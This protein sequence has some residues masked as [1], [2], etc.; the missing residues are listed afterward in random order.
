MHKKLLFNDLFYFRIFSIILVL[1]LFSNC[2]TTENATRLEKWSWMIQEEDKI[3]ESS[4]SEF[5]KLKPLV[6]R[7][8]FFKEEEATIEEYDL[9]HISSRNFAENICGNIFAQEIRSSKDWVERVN[10]YIST[11]N[12]NVETLEKSFNYKLPDYAIGSCQSVHPNKQFTLDDILKFVKKIRENLDNPQKGN[13]NARFK[14]LQNRIRSPIVN[15]KNENRSELYNKRE[16][17]IQKYRAFNSSVSR[18]TFNE[19]ALSRLALMLAYSFSL[20]RYNQPYFGGIV[21]VGL[22]SSANLLFS[23]RLKD[24]DRVAFLTEL[25]LQFYVDAISKSESLL[26]ET[27]YILINDKENRLPGFDEFAAALDFQVSNLEEIYQYFITKDGIQFRTKEIEAICE[28]YKCNR[29]PD[30][31]LLKKNAKATIGELKKRR[32][33][34]SLLN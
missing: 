32:M 34:S 25:K 12:V 18:A 27:H 6:G 2:T 20:S 8:K 33:A 3:F 16:T 4:I 7:N 19:K 23:P 11:R 30:M 29:Q 1:L 21:F 13:R 9:I 24:N 26:N 31:E 10:R 28:K 5:G 14:S 17:I 22:L 15:E